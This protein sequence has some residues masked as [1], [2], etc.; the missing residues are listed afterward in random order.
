MA[1]TTIIITLG[2]SGFTGWTADLFE[3]G[4]DNAAVAS[5]KAL[6]ELTNNKGKYSISVTEAAVGDF[7]LAIY[8]SDGDQV[9]AGYVI[10][11]TDTASTFYATNTP[12]EDAGGLTGANTVTITVTDGANAI[13]DAKVR[14]TNGPDTD[15]RATDSSGEVTFNL[16]NGDWTVS[17]TRPGFTF[18][19]TTLAVDGPETATYAMDAL[20]V[21][22][23]EPGFCTG[24]TTVYDEAGEPE[25]GVTIKLVAHR[26]PP[27]SGVMMDR[28]PY[29][30]VSDENGYVEWPNLIQQAW[31]VLIRGKWVSQPFQVPSSATFEF[32]NQVG[33]DAEAS[34]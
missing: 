12:P 17:I 4:Q 3:H 18:A 13:P 15:I 10:G 9:G 1:T 23:S 28:M 33:K 20:S 30:A 2:H 7:D 19:G 27:G 5:G 32:P 21:T 34:T 31:Y 8:N 29:E 14:V 22:P 25:E 6:T 24:F 26:P 11:L 16:D